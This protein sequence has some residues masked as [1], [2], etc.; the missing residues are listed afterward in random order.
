MPEGIDP[1]MVARALKAVPGVRD[2]HDLHIWSITSGMPSLSAHLVIDGAG[3]ADDIRKSAVEVL[4][5]KFEIEH[6]TLQTETKDCRDD[7]GLR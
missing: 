3:N 2:L 5:A 7:R 4:D 6:V 1:E